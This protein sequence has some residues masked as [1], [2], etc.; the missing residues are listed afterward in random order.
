MNAAMWC[1]ACS[2]Q[3]DDKA[4]F[5]DACGAALG[6]AAQSEIQAAAAP[7]A[8]TAAPRKSW[9]RPGVG[10]YAVSGV[11]AAL[12]ALVAAAIWWPRPPEVTADA[13]RSAMRTAIARGDSPGR[14]PIC[15]A[16]GLAYDQEPVNVEIDNAATV[17]WMNVLVSA[18][19]YAAP[20]NGLSGGA[21]SQAIF[22]YKPLPV[23]AEWAGARRLCIARAVKLESVA[24]LGRV[25]DMRLRG[26]PY[27]GVP[28]DVRWVLDQPAPWLDNP[29]VAEAL[30]RELPT[31]RS[32][33][34]EL[35]AKSWRLTQRKNFVRIDKQWVPG[36][37]ADRPPQRAGTDAT[38]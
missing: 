11:G 23:L 1:A 24:N 31:W 34:W 30:A 21:V 3:V 4:P 25:D 37:L 19:L 9:W 13:L 28:A 17:S 2:K 18:G 33:R 36:D 35:A 29:G 5:C 12:L 15:V 38:L 20:A 8:S 26:K 7:T 22:V 6:S 27:T 32:A 14:D 10:H 16:N